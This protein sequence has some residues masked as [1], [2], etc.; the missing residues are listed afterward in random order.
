MELHADVKR[1]TGELHR[2]DQPVVRRGARENHAML[3]KN[4]P[5]AVVEFIAVAVAFLHFGASVSLLQ[6]SAGIDFAGISAEPHG[7]A[8][9]QVALLIGHQ[10][11][12]RVRAVGLKLTGIRFRK[13]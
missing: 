5:V 13:A 1:V 3:A 10:I 12:D 11:D 7:A 9:G 2:F 4:I 6:E 8:L